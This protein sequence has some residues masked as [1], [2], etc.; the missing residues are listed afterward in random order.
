MS[1]RQNLQN[2]L[3]SYLARSTVG[4]TDLKK[5]ISTISARLPDTVIFGG[6][7]REFSLGRVRK[8]TSD[9]DLVSMHSRAEIHQAI[10]HH[11]PIINKF[12]GFRFIVD[13][14]RFD[15]WSFYDTWAFKEGHISPTAQTDLLKTT[16]FNLDAA[17]YHI[18]K[19][20]IALLEN[21]E[22]WV[23]R[24]ILDINLKE[25][26]HPSSMCRRAI[27]LVTTRQLG[28]TKNLAEF[29]LSN[30]DT[31]TTTWTENLFVSNLH[32]FIN[33]NETSLFHFSP[34]REI[35]PR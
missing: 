17:F 21:Y 7:L 15:I 35:P 6:M 24:K 2:S 12:G 20:E 14:Q 3:I 4:R 13:K 18:S 23:A 11:D 33:S 25:N 9:I 22:L 27:S 8:F 1:L 19:K 29:I 10:L 16:F 34:Q 28:M 30:V 26:P 5:T 31:S 32:K